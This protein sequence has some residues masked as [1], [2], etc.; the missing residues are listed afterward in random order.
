MV[1]N[2]NYFICSLRYILANLRFPTP[3]KNLKVLNPP[4]TLSLAYREAIYI[5]GRV[6]PGFY[7]VHPELSAKIDPD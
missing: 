1:K 4:S 6:E 3:S 5:P 2:Q 7:N